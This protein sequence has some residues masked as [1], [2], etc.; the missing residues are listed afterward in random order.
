[1]SK[2]VGVV[3]SEIFL[4]HD[5]GYGHPECSERLVSIYGLLDQ[6]GLSKELKEV[7][8]RKASKQEICLV[9]SDYHYSVIER[10]KGRNTYLDGDTPASADSF[11]TALYAVGSLLA[12][13][14]QV[15]SGK[16]KT[17]FA[18][19]RPP[20]HHAEQERAMGFCLFNNIAI[21]SAW[22]V[23]EKGLKRVL[24]VDFDVH[25]GNGTQHSFYG[26]DQVLYFS[27][28]RYPFYPGTGWFNEVGEGKGE[29]FTVNVPLPGGAGDTELDAIY[30]KVLMPIAREYKPEL[31]MVSAGFDAYYDDPLG[32]M[33]VSEQGY[34]RLGSIFMDLA[35]ELCNGRLIFVLEGGYSLEG[36]AKCIQAIILR[37]I[38]K[39]KRINQLEGKPVGGLEKI[40]NGVYKFQKHYWKGIE[41]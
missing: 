8:L 39:E 24:V 40:L 31:I 26:T 25:H 34:A 15:L 16:L 28:H 41:I 3:R 33:E 5:T 10:T 22:A 18:L 38:G 29:G 17:G 9:H 6:S 36:I 4:N 12:L 2:S 37:M 7:E 27:S 20:G 1:M 13:T 11:E 21:A 14:E 35:D 19:V 30:S 32:G 23:K